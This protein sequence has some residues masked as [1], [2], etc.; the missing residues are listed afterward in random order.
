M[1]DSVGELHIGFDPERLDVDNLWAA[2]IST[3]LL[4]P[5]CCVDSTFHLFRHLP[6]SCL[7]LYDFI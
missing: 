1:P 6:L 3:L 7:D 4:S 5:I 2:K